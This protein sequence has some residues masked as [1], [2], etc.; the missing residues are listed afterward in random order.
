MR[1]FPYQYF[2][3]ILQGDYD[4]TKLKVLHFTMN[5]SAIAQQ[6]RSTELSRLKMENEKLMN[7]VKILEEAGAEA[8]DVTKQVEMKM[9]EPSSSKDIEGM[10]LG[11]RR[12]GIWMRQ[13]GGGQ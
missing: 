11:C 13:G 9:Q 3:V 8:M 12:G 4:P 10:L 2:Y 6:E 1:I 7:R 5:P